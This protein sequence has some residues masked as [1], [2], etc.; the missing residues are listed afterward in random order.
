MRRWPQ[1]REAVICSRLLFVLWD[2]MEAGGRK[3]FKSS[4]LPQA[5]MGD[6]K[7]MNWFELVLWEV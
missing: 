4:S 3:Q 6:R 7:E 5:E 2:E 1:S